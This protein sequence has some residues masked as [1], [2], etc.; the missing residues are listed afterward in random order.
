MNWKKKPDQDRAN[1]TELYNAIGVAVIELIGRT[2]IRALLYV[3]MAEGSF[4]TAIRYS[5]ADMPG[6][7]GA[8]ASHDLTR[9]LLNLCDFL[10][11]QG[12]DKL[13][14]AMEYLADHGDVDISLSY[15]EID[16]DMAIWERSP[17]VIDK[18]FPGKPFYKD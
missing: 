11:S 6:V 5:S 8:F 17:A 15:D 4:D 1:E 12:D 16:Q 10:K 9:A 13:W 18:Y 7:K 2:D 14:T 3:E